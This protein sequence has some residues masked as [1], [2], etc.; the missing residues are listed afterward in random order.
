M[1]RLTYT[2]N[3]GL[4][5]S[6]PVIANGNTV[7]VVI[8]PTNLRYKVTNLSGEHTFSDGH[9]TNLTELKK[10]AKK[11]LKE[12]GVA[13]TSEVRQRKQVME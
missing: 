2:E 4:L 8:D 11:A 1:V 7:V 5:T 10:Q 3:N 6:K 9:S 13:F 12:L